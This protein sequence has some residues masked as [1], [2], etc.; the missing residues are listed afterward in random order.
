MIMLEIEDL[1]A[2]YG[3]SLVLLGMNLNV[4]KGEVACILGRN[5]MGKTTTLRAIM[6]LVQTVRGTVRLEGHNLS[7]VRAY[8]IPRR[9]IGYV[10]QGR[11]IFPEFTVREN[12]H[13]GV[14]KGRPD[15][16]RLDQILSMFPRLKERLNQSG[17]SLS[18]GEQQML[19]IGRALLPGPKLLLLD[20]PTEGLSPL[21]AQVVRDAVRLIKASGI[22]IVLVEQHPREALALADSISIIE[23]GAVR[24]HE[25][26]EQF[27]TRPERLNDYLGLIEQF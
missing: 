10:P 15:S 20:E 1:H 8:Q 24:V 21:M 14:M 25:K 7:A 13:S 22:T 27:L 2:S 9:G 23:K 18:G 4:V 5:G 26:R 12:L 11:H 6:G 19:A 17:G 3:K 16:A